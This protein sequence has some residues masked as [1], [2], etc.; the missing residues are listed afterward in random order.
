MD[1]YAIMSL[2]ILVILSFWHAIIGGLIFIYT[3]DSR[4]ISRTWFVYS[5]RFVLCISIL[6]YIII[7]VIL[8][9]WLCCVPLKHRRRLKERDVHYRELISKE[10]ELSKTRLK[11]NSEYFR[12][13][14]QS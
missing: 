13:S 14:S 1:K 2:F 8:L 11:R 9:I 6:I 4:L 3:P 7:H 12:L 10:S 5:D